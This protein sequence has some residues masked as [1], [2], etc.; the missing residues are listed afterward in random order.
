MMLLARPTA[1]G[2]KVNQLL[3]VEFLSHP[4]NE[5]VTRMYGKPSLTVNFRRTKRVHLCSVRV[6]SAVSRRV[7]RTSVWW[8]EINRLPV[9]V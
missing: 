2:Y 7:R 5:I 8:K 1:H 6:P 3:Y 4:N 9:R